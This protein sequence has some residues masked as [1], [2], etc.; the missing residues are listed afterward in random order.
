[1]GVCKP[2][3]RKLTSVLRCVVYNFC[4][5]LFYPILLS[6][7]IKVSQHK[8]RSLFSVYQQ[9]ILTI[10]TDSQIKNQITLF[11]RQDTNIS[12]RQHLH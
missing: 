9:S 11:Y 10:N 2:M 1:M 3:T 7:F 4:L 8:K 6:I 12:Q 5:S